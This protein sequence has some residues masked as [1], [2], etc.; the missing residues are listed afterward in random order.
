M[1]S[2]W[3]TRLED[4]K[5]VAVLRPEFKRFRAAAIALWTVTALAI[6]AGAVTR[7]DL[8]WVLAILFA[9]AAAFPTGL[10]L[11]M[12]R[13]HYTVVLDFGEGT[14][15][16]E[17][18][19]SFDPP[20]VFEARIEEFSAE[21]TGALLTLRRHDGTEPTVTNEAQDADEAL[22]IAQRVES[23]QQDR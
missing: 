23:E 4:E 11:G 8:A 6:A 16:V 21:A 17:V 9:C 7:H 19:R 10:W 20:E 18:V 12:R 2:G 3:T 22:A 14:I 13:S 15:Q 1:D 5:Y